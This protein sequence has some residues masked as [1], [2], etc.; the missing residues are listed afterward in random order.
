MT[1]E[2]LTTGVQ[3]PAVALRRAGLD[4][5]MLL[6]PLKPR[7]EIIEAVGEHAIPRLAQRAQESGQ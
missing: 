2:S 5:M 6:P 1:E 3:V 7:V 4:Q